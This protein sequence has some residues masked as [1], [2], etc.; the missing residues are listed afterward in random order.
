MINRI[1]KNFLRVPYNFRLQLHVLYRYSFGEEGFFLTEKTPRFYQEI[2][3]K[4]SKTK[5]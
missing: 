4:K 1:R 3:C 2:F 5:T